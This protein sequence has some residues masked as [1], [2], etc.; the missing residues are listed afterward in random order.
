M[1][2][3]IEVKF[4]DIDHD[5]MRVKLRDMGAHLE[6]PMRLMR[7]ALFDHDDGRL[8]ATS[9][10]Q[11][12]VRDEGDKITITFKTKTQ[13]TVDGVHEIETTVGDYDIMIELLE[14]AG[15]HVRSRQESKRETWRLGDSEVVLDEWPWLKPYIEIEGPSE[16]RL[17]EIATQLGFDWKDAV[18]GSV[19]EAYRAEYDFADEQAIGTNTVI[20]FDAPVPEWMAKLKK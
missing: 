3:E 5:V 4:L 1:Q 19:T 16:A 6:Q 13:E 7:R 18:I 15:L 2:P 11:L 14:A 12:R 8:D 10:S 20:A 17:R 9:R